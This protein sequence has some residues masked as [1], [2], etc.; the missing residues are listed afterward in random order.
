MRRRDV[1]LGVAVAVAWG[2]NFVAIGQG[3]HDLPPLLFVGLRYSFAAVP[4]VFLVRPP[5]VSRGKVVQLGLLGGVG[6]FGL[7]FLGVSAGMPAGLSSVVLQAQMP[8]TVLLGVVLLHE[9]PGR[10]QLVGLGT[11][12][13]GL[14]LVGAYRGAA[15]P[16]VAVALVVAAGACWAGA[17]AVAGAARSTRP[18]SLL[19]H[20]SAVSAPVMLGLSLVFEGPRRDLEALQGMDREAFLSLAYVVVIATV[21]GYGAWYW[22]LARYDSSAVSAFPLL[23]PVAALSSAWVLLDEAVPVGQLVGAG[24]AVGGVAV[25]VAGS[26]R[27]PRSAAGPST[28]RVTALVGV[29]P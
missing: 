19:V 12:V 7:L 2:L 14:V 20:A 18:F 29:E 10:R 9:R 27:Q 13:C 16:L 4:L 21:A 15:V 5:D 3:L 22:L 6:Q 25:A 17:N 8:F 1:L 28:P 26:G 11:A 23:A 24:L